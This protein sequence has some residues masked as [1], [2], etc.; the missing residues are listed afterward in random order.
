M[1][2]VVLKDHPWPSIITIAVGPPAE[3]DRYIER[4]TGEPEPTPMEECRGKH[5]HFV[6]GKRR[7]DV[8]AVKRA[9]D[10]KDR[11]CSLSHEAVHLAQS[12]LGDYAGMPLTEE[13]DEAYAYLIG[14]IVEKG[15]P[16]L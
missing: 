12:L 16:L 14:W 15:L 8:I 1:K 6:D 4:R 7:H 10:R 13:S 5:I 11:I 3:L 2:K 9:H